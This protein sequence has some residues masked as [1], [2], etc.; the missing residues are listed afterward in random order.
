MTANPEN[1]KPVRTTEEAR[2]RGRNGGIKS[3]KVRRH[4]KTLKEIGDM[5]GGLDITSPKNREILKAAGIED[6]DLVNDVGMVFML[7]QRAL[8]GDPRAFK[9]L[10][11]IRGQFK[12]Q[13]SAEV[14]DVKPLIDLRDRKKNGD[15]DGTG[16]D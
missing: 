9:I 5:I 4:R 7:S 11:T 2:R 12:E 10:A 8:K 6:E 1:L 3:G 14:T 15:H 13:I 16:K